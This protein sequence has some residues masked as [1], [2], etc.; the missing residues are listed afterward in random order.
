MISK[1]TKCYSIY[2]PNNVCVSLNIC[3]YKTLNSNNANFYTVPT[4]PVLA[5]LQCSLNASAVL[6]VR[7]VTAKALMNPFQ[8]TCLFQPENYF[9]ENIATS[10]D[11]TRPVLSKLLSQCNF[12]FTM[13]YS[14]F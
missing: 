9:L 4:P 6:Y 11:E 7:P 2:I 13:T 12:S 10:Q 14:S 8:G 3:I 5:C 1:I